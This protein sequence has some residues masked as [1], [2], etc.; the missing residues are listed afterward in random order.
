[1]RAVVNQINVMEKG[2]E[3]RKCKSRGR[4]QHK[5]LDD[6]DALYEDMH[7]TR[8]PLL[9]GEVRG[10]ERIKKFAGWLLRPKDA[11]R[12]AEEGEDEVMVKEEV[13]DS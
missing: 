13:K 4:M 6:I 10:V 5:Y 7:V 3:C 11:M 1:M 12:L 8:M 2:S 9:E